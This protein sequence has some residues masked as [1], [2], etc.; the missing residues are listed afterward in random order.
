[1]KKISVVSF[2][3][4]GGLSTIVDSQPDDLYIT[5][6]SFEDRSSTIIDSLSFGYKASIGIIYI[7]EDIASPNT[8]PNTIKKY[9]YIKNALEKYVSKIL[10]ITGSQADSLKQ[11]INIRKCLLQL[12][13]QSTI[14]R[15]TI[16]STTFNREAL[17]II[18]HLLRVYWPSAKIRVLYVSPDNYGEWLSK[19]FKRVK[20]IIGFTGNFDAIK[21]TL[22]VVLSGFEVDRTIKIIDDY[23]PFIILL[24]FADPPSTKKFL[25]RN[26]LEQ[27]AN[28]SRND[29]KKFVF[30]CNDIVKCKLKIQEVIE[31]YLEY[32]N[33]AVAPMSTKLS[34]ISCM[35][36]A[37][38]NQNIQ[39]SYSIPDVYN[40]ES[41]SFGY[42]NL[43]INYLPKI[44]K[45]Q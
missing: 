1:M 33:I 34:T 18:T 38:E 25:D 32:Y 3:E 13:E 42:K 11:F 36:V 16:D 35:L 44:S 24:G 15:I 23:E 26:Y 27:R 40:Q 17:I 6:A 30:P 39:L 14:K 12:K 19:G 8:S 9:Q 21:P 43:Y 10:D 29:V 31:P 28:L 22:L 2:R 4:K 5:C 37:L 7:N 20:S 41:Y 45:K